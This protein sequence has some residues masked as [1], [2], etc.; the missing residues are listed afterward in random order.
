MNVDS[1]LQ[2]HAEVA[3]ALAGFASVAAVLQR[4]LS[5]IARQNFLTILFSALIQ[6]LGSLVPVW[7]S[8]LDIDGPL[9]WRVASAFVLVLSLTLVTLFFTRTLGEPNPVLISKPVTY[10]TNFLTVIIF[11][12]LVLNVVGVPF[13]PSFGLYYMQL[14]LGITIVFVS[15]ANAVVGS[16]GEAR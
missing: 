9:L 16:H 1:L 4:P 15:F 10:I 5:P 7:L 12:A 6:L 11:I 2:T 13:R 8:S 14:L 3:V